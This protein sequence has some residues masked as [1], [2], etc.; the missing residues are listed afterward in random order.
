MEE[1]R[2]AFKN[3]TGK[4]IGKRPLVWEDNIRVDLNLLCAHDMISRH[5]VA[6]M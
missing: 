4:H 1:R 3:L 2:S 6:V 5:I